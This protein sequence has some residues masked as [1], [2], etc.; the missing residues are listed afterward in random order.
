[1]IKSHKEGS[2]ECLNENWFIS[3]K[4]ARAIVE[5]WRIDYNEADLT[6]YP[7]A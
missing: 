1:M 6:A 5:N 7:E 4:N 3:L 2:S